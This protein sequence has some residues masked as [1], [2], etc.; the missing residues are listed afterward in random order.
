M[1]GHGSPPAEDK[2]NHPGRQVGRS[3]ASLAPQGIGPVY[4]P[5]SPGFEGVRGAADSP[6]SADPME[7]RLRRMGATGASNKGW[8]KNLVEKG[9]DG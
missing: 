1:A 4:G 5:P 2:A 3:T 8:L 7:A 6:A 9:M